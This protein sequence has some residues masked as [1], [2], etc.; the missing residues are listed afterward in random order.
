MGPQDQFPPKKMKNK[1]KIVVL[2]TRAD[3]NGG[4]ATVMNIYNDAGLYQR[5]DIHF[6]PTHCSGNVIAKIRVLLPTAITYLRMLLC[7]QIAV[8]HTHSASGVSFWRKSVFL[9]LA[10]LFRIPTVLQVHS[11]HF[12]RFYNDRCNR[13]QKKLIRKILRSTH[14]I[15][16]VSAELERFIATLAQRNDI[17]IIHNPA[18]ISA[19]CGGVR[20]KNIILFLGHLGPQKGT[21]DLIYAMKIVSIKNAEAK[22]MLCGD[23]NLEDARKL[24]DH[25]GLT[26]QIKVTGWI[27][28]DERTQ[29]L[30]EAAIYV[31]PSYA[32]GLPMSILE[33]MS[34]GIPTVAT[35]V[36]GIPE[37]IT[38]KR[39]G[40]LHE[41]GDIE[42]LAEHLLY[43]LN[44][45]EIREEMGKA[46]KEKVSQK[47][48]ISK[49]LAELKGIYETLI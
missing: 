18:R 40:L 19:S 24:I 35:S 38:H 31:L 48:S 25:M 6:M 14:K 26:E 4:I 36:G 21:S 41:P 32:E 45:T 39:E 29:L 37:A 49:S 15:V 23:G 5:K 1:K 22:L 42:T 16:V 13:L 43:L 30:N 12:P 7:N 10:F 46:A 47:F 28:D 17:A 33:A 44:E 20:S 3:A 11:G 34:A 8:V 27:N 9:A 2:G